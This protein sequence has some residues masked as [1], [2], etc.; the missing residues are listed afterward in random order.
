MLLVKK[1]ILSVFIILLNL[2]NISAIQAEE[3]HC[4]KSKKIAVISPVQHQA[5]DDII[6]GVKA[7]LKETQD[8]RKVV[9]L[10]AMGDTNN[11]SSIITQLAN[12]D[13]YDVLMPIG[14]I[15]THLALNSTST[16][17]IIGLGVDINE[18]ERQSFIKAGHSNFTSVKDEIP[19]QNI[20]AFIKKL[21]RKN[22][23]LVYSNDDRIHKT[24]VEAEN[25]A[26]HYDLTIKKFNIVN[27][28]DIY[29]IKTAMK[30]FDCVLVLKDHMVVSMINVLVEAAHEYS[31]PLIASDEGSV[32]SG[33]DI[34]IGVKEK[35]IGV[36]G[37]DI[38]NE[39]IAGKK[40]VNIPVKLLSDIR[41][42]Y[43]IGCC[44]PLEQKHIKELAK[45]LKYEFSTVE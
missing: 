6:S 15:A 40:V 24:V 30:G 5:M 38:L 33:A 29:G 42:F 14:S 43:R 39:I 20:F 36:A 10:N 13:E 44:N 21:E 23:L 35:E 11:I 8:D 37:V 4:T 12:N 2:I 3:C 9:V 1:K 28:S 22:I 32:I 19:I 25:T 7:K 17:P 18:A 26:K 27:P 41:V 31:L 34:A 16:K 45:D